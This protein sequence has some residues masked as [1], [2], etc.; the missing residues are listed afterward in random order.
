MALLLCSTMGSWG[1]GSGHG[2]T[3]RGS[4]V[5]EARSVTGPCARTPHPV[6]SAQLG[7]AAGLGLESGCQPGGSLGQRPPRC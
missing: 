2:P 5:L 7:P 1:K 4:P 6:Q 3:V